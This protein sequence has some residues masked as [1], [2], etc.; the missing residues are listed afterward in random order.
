[1]PVGNARPVQVVGR[2]LDVDLVAD[3]DADEIFAHFAGDVSEHFMAVGQSHAEHRA[4]QHLRDVSHQF[5]WLF[6]G[7]WTSLNCGK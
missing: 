6:F 5:N 7:H 2:H 4:G 1:M 3:A